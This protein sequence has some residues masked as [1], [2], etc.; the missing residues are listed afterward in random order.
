MPPA[1]KRPLN[2]ARKRRALPVLA[3]S[4][5]VLRALAANRRLDGDPTGTFVL[6]TFVLSTFV[7]RTTALRIDV[8]DKFKSILPRQG[9]DKTNKL[10]GALRETFGCLQVHLP[11]YPYKLYLPA[12]SG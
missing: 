11:L 4:D 8:G 6:R 12:Q 2:H 10:A 3:G 9:S 5:I 7:L 1:V